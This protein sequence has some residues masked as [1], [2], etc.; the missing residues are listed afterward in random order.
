M[1]P[2]RKVTKHVVHSTPTHGTLI[3]LFNTNIGMEKVVE[4]FLMPRKSLTMSNKLYIQLNGYSNSFT[5]VNHNRN[6]EIRTC[7]RQYIP[8][9]FHLKTRLLLLQN[10]NQHQLYI[11]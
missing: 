9:P 7:A 10:S 11:S 8:Y 3:H 6:P 2:R 4:E 5:R 1:A